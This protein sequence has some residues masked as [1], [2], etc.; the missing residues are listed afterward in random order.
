M[1]IL[2]YAVIVIFLTGC[3]SRTDTNTHIRSDLNSFGR[4]SE[5]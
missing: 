5:C 2:K 3:L 1:R 4:L